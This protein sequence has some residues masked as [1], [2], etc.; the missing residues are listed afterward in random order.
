[1]CAA[2][3]R[4]DGF[5]GGSARPLSANCCAIACRALDGRAFRLLNVLDNFDREGL[6]TEVDFSLPAERVTAIVGK[7]ISQIVV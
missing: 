2:G 1:M 7:T 6:G 4:V 3:Q 5:H